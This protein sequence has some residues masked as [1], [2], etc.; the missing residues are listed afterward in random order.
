[1]NLY[2]DHLEVGVWGVE[3]LSKKGFLVDPLIGIPYIELQP[4]IMSICCATLPTEN[5]T[6]L[7]TR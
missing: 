3:I 2:P 5:I 7:S 6:L 4:G 1:M